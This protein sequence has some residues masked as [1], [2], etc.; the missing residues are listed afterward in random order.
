[1]KTFLIKLV[2]QLDK[3]EVDTWRDFSLTLILTLII[4]AFINSIKWIWILSIISWI[5]YTIINAL[6]IWKLDIDRNFNPTATFI[7]ALIGGGLKSLMILV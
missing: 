5:L 6:I 4:I 2:N 7:G 1:M 3:L